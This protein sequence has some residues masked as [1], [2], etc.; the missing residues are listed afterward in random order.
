M[1][2]YRIRNAAKNKLYKTYKS[3]KSRCNNPNVPEYHRYGGR[4]IRVCDIWEN[5]YDA[6]REWAIENG[7]DESLSID[8]IDNDGNYEP[9]NCRWVDMLTQ[10]RNKSNNRYIEIDGVK[11]TTSEWCEL[12]NI[13][14]HTF[15]GRIREGWSDEDALKTPSK[16]KRNLDFEYNGVTKSIPQWAKEYG[17]GKTTLKYRLF[18][19]W[20]I[21]DALNTPIDPSRQPLCKRKQKKEAY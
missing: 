2:D 15:Y 1:D 3:M 17:I 8:R 12:Y 16:G 19:G 20:S 9:S 5:D 6:F 7:Y 14:L 21:E 4:G 10:Q 13:N 18:A 11:K